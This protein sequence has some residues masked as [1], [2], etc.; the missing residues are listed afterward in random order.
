MLNNLIKE[1]EAKIEEC[2]KLLDEST[3]YGMLQYQIEAKRSAFI[4]SLA[5]IKKH[6]SEFEQEIK[7][8]YSEGSRDSQ[9]AEWT[10]PQDYY[11]QNYKK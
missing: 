4:S 1:L 8:A 5:I 10:S 9:K 2:N 7:D 3:T 6:E 11:N